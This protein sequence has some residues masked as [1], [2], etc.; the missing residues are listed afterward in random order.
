M[1][2]MRAE[3]LR[4][5][6]EERAKTEKLLAKL[7][8]EKLPDEKPVEPLDERDRSYNSQFNPHIARKRKKRDEQEEYHH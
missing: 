2:E 7:R 3:R 8:G 4:R 6:Q 1:A 5:E